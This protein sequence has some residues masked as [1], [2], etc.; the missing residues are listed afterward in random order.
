MLFKRTAFSI[1]LLTIIILILPVK[2][3]TWDNGMYNKGR[4]MMDWR[5]SGSLF[6]LTGKIIVDTSMSALSRMGSMRPAMYYLDTVGNGSKNY[7]LFFGPYWYKPKNGLTKPTDGQNI[8][9]KG[10]KFNFSNPPMFV[11]Y[12][13]NDSLWRDTS[14]VEPWSGNWIHKNDTDSTKIYCPTDSLSFMHLPPNVMGTGMMGN[15]MMWT[16]SLF[17]QFEQM[18]PDSIPGTTKGQSLIGFHID[19]S[20]PSGSTMMDMGNQNN[21][22]MPMKQ[23]VRCTF[24]IPADSLTRRGLTMSQLSVR[25]MDKSGN[26]NV[27]VSV[28]ADAQNNTISFTQSNLYSF[29]DVVPTSVTAINTENSTVPVQYNLYQNYPN[30]FNPGTKIKYSIPYES[31]ITLKIYDILG[32]EIKE[33]VNETQTPGVHLVNFNAADLTSGIYFYRITA[34]SLKNKSQFT[35]VKKLILIK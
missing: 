18:M 11:V 32:K 31:H 1:F 3:Q 8:T 15:G 20:N 6:S 16:D 30:P 28:N 23:G 10:I 21:G 24:N 34:A 14:G 13:I 12:I 33:L 29:Y 2:S 25:Y 5:G 17:C 26:W 35:S 4:G 22:M 9:A 7:Q 27:I 19:M